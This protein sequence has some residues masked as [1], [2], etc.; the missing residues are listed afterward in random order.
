MKINTKSKLVLFVLLV[1]TLALTVRAVNSNVYANTFTELKVNIPTGDDA[2]TIEYSK[3]TGAKYCVYG[4]YEG[5]N[6]TKISL[7]ND[8]ETYIE[9]AISGESDIKNG[10]IISNTSSQ[11]NT[12]ESTINVNSYITNDKGQYYILIGAK[13][14]KNLRGTLKTVSDSSANK[15]NNEWN[16]YKWEKWNDN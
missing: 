13:D 6:S 4:P 7:K 9:V 16:N 2:K 11:G 1:A 12:I 3:L 15:K 14:I 5:Y 10:Q 8:I